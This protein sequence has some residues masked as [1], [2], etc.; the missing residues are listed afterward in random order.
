MY[1]QNN[2]NDN[3]SNIKKKSTKDEKNNINNVEQKIQEM[4]KTEKKIIK[5]E[6]LNII[7][8][9]DFNNCDENILYRL[10]NTAE[11]EIFEAK[12]SN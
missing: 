2:Q 9:K 4:K 1:K 12:T 5:V 3:N 6:N 11:I 7:L 8:N 10:A